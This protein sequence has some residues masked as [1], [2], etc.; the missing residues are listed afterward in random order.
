[1]YDI[2]TQSQVR[3]TYTMWHSTK[4]GLDS[5][6]GTSVFLS[7]NLLCEFKFF[8]L[9]SFCLCICSVNVKCP[10]CID[11]CQGSVLSRYMIPVLYH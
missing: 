2:Y 10:V 9:L 1:M 7:V 4:H 3:T 6:T 8:A 5:W 11:D